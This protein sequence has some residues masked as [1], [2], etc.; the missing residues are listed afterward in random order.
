V[1]AARLAA[2]AGGAVSLAAPLAMPGLAARPG[3]GRDLDAAAERTLV[4]LAAP[5]GSA[6]EAEEAPFRG[7]RQRTSAGGARDAGTRAARAATAFA[8]KRDTAARAPSPIPGIRPGTFAAPAAGP[9]LRVTVPAASAALSMIARTAAAAGP[10][11]F[12]RVADRT[13]IAAAPV[14]AGPSGLPG[15]AA[16]AAAASAGL[17]VAEEFALLGIFAPS[18]SQAVAEEPAQSRVF[19]ERPVAAT[20]IRGPVRTPASA[21]APV[22]TAT[23]VPRPPKPGSLAASLALVGPSASRATAATGRVPSRAG[24]G[25]PSATASGAAGSSAPVPVPGQDTTTIHDLVLEAPSIIEAELLAQP[26][27]RPLTG[28]VVTNAAPDLV[29]VQRTLAR[30]LSALAPLP[31]VTEGDVLSFLA[32]TGRPRRAAGAS[33]AAAGPRRGPGEDGD[34][35][36]VDAGLPAGAAESRSAVRPTAGRPEL[37]GLPGR[38]HGTD[39]A[40]EAD[41]DLVS[42]AAATGSPASS[43]PMPSPAIPATAFPGSPAGTGPAYRGSLPLVAP[44][45]SAVAATAMMS[46]KAETRPAAAKPETVQAQAGDKGPPVDLDA[47]AAEMTDRIAR[48]LRRDKERRGFHG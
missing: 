37:P 19:P 25:I 26:E 39:R 8:G 42:P 10:E 17:P 7:A 46:R 31:G 4:E 24:V 20:A 9:G 12:V 3:A 15:P 27:A 6:P 48:R 5:E 35:I 13:S 43:R 28:S 45:L 2:T 23:V 44:A 29:L 41:F 47:L 34:R 22:R 11:G 32:G 18:P 14:A 16:P 33:P 1:V 30:A 40:P 36:L 38:E 21:T